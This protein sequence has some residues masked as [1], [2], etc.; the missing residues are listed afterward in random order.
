MKT[1]SK[2][3]L[4]IFAVFAFFMIS[5]CDKVEE[6]TVV[7]TNYVGYDFAIN[8]AKDTNTKVSMLLEPGAEIHGYEP[9]ATD[10]RTILSAS[11]F[12]YVGGESDEEWVENSIL[13]SIDSSKTKVVNMFELLENN[14]NSTLYHEAEIEGDEHEHEEGE[15]H[16][17][18]HEHEE[19]YDEHVWN[20][21]NNATIILAGIKDALISASSNNKDSY[22]KNALSYTN[23]INE[24]KTKFETL[25]A[26]GTKKMVIADRFPLLYFMNEFKIE[27]DAALSGCS[28]AT[29]TSANTLIRLKNVVE[30]NSLKA[31]F[32][33]ELS[34]QSIA[35][36]L[37]QEIKNDITNGTYTGSEVEILT[38]YSMHNISKDD[39]NN[40]LTYVDYLNKNYTTMV[41]YLA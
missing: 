22:E 31:I 14:P 8:V 21:L 26:K 19:E 37:K 1:I 24:V 13:P 18:D 3:S 40:G 25:F 38:F 17:H 20:D 15:A 12:I 39:F 33:I 7:A 2:I 36:S 32:T 28:T 30:E 27:Y 9:S 35:K 29:E 11:V 23:S 16:D 5:S 34:T 41:N 4:F 10:I 6:G